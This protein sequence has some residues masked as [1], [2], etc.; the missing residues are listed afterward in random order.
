MSGLQLQ[1]YEVVTA[2]GRTVQI[3]YD[4]EGDM[5]ELFF[6]KGPASGA[7]ELADPVILRFDRETGRA[8]SLSIL[9]FSQVTQ[10]TEL[11]PRSFP[12]SGLERLPGKMRE[13]IARMITTPPV[14]HFLKVMA[15]YPQ[16]EQTL[17]A[18]SYI[19]RS[20]ALPLA[21]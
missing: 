12:L 1:R 3:E 21:A 14:S 10:P 4:P 17:I 5:V 2:E 11:R 6:D 8:L 9:T 18:L 20:V 19:E 15:Y 7:V 16:A 13:Q